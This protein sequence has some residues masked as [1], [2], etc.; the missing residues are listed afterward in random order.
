VSTNRHVLQG[1][2]ELANV[3]WD[4]AGKKLSGIAKIIGG[5]PFRIILANNGRKN[6]RV[7][8]AGSRVRM[9]SHPAGKDFAI[10]VLERKDSK[11]AYW[12]VKYK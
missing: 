4:S 5:E 11:E 1:W 2:V 6:V 3:K 7:I 8:S 10:V 12:E 9:E